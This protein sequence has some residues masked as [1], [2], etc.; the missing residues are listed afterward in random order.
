MRLF[1]PFFLLRLVYPG[2]IFRVTTTDKELCLTFDDGPHPE[3]TPHILEILEAGNVKAVF[4]CNGQEAAKNPELVDL[5]VSKGH[6][7]GNHGYRHLDGWKTNTRVY[8]SDFSGSEKFI[9]QNFLRPPYGRIR[10]AQYKELSKKYKIV[11]W[12][13]MPYDFDRKLNSKDVFKILKKK[14]RPGSVIVLHDKNSSSCLSFLAEFIKY[15][16]DNGYKFV[17]PPFSGKK[18]TSLCN[19]TFKATVNYGA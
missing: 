11:F 4:F 3:T 18:Q 14:T 19:Q 16:A 5:I 9:S 12:D 7:V 8:I 2:A 13:L 17:T 1:R 15:T 10:P 6:I